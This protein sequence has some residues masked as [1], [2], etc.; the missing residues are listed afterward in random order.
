MGIMEKNKSINP[1]FIQWLE[2]QTYTRTSLGWPY[3]WDEL[4]YHSK[5]TDHILEYTWGLWRK[6]TL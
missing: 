3:V 1:E 6:I 4:I 2:K 5:L